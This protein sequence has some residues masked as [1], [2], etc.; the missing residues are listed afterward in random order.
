MT[1]NKKSL[2]ADLV[3]DKTL[4]KGTAE[5]G[6]VDGRVPADGHQRTDGHDH[7]PAASKMA[8]RLLAVQVLYALSFTDEEA[9]MTR[10][11]VAE[12]ETPRKPMSHPQKVASNMRLAK[13][14]MSEELAADIAGIKFQSP[15]QTLTDELLVDY[16]QEQVAMEQKI[17]A[18]L[19][20]GRRK[21]LSL[22]R[23]LKIILVLGAVELRQ[24]KLEPAIIISAW[25]EVAKSYFADQSPRLIHAVLDA[26]YKKMNQ[27]I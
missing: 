21:F 13:K 8:A 5:Q 12:G 3:S 23:L 9:G 7:N 11:V 27:P 26:F 6:G 20:G 10:A 25:V 18:E 17:S 16:W 4:G 19:S 14:I 15:Y 24:S 1:D 22:E 2:G